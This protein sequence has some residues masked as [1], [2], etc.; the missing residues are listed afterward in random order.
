MQ[1]RT[2]GHQSPSIWN[3][4]LHETKKKYKQPGFDP[5]QNITPE[6]PSSLDLDSSIFFLF[7]KI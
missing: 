4:T 7:F 5:I 3:H 2:K 1:V 6:F